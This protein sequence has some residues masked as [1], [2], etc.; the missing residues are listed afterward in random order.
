MPGQSCGSAATGCGFA[1][2]P[3]RWGGPERR[4]GDCVSKT[5]GC[6]FFLAL[7][8]LGLRIERLSGC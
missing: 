8:S 2:F 7:L 5:A 3:W 6:G 4:F 1:A